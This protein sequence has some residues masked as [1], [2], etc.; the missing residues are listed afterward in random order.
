MYVVFPNLPNLTLP[1]TS[2]ASLFGM[3]NVR[4]AVDIEVVMSCHAKSFHSGTLD[5]RI[6]LNSRKILCPNHEIE[7]KCL[8]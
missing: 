4:Y 2:D 5:T 8:E 1:N 3:P 6:M 7:S